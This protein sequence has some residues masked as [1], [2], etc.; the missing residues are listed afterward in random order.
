MLET[1]LASA[2]TM[3][4]FAASPC[5]DQTGAIDALLNHARRSSGLQPVVYDSGLECAAL[6]HAIDITPKRLCRHQGSDG[7]SFQQRVARCTTIPA[8]SEI[9]ACN[10]P[11]VIGV[12]ATW[13]NE[14]RLRQ[15][16]LDPRHRR[17][18]CA[19]MPSTD[20]Q[21]LGWY[22]VVFGTDAPEVPL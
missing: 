13:W 18:G 7:S 1:I 19:K 20:D 14:Q 11:N 5:D 17:Y 9:M 21:K 16:M 15:V 10:Y 3:S 4:S 2:L 22:V 6:M 12:Y 8:A